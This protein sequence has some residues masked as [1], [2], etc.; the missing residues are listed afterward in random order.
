[1]SSIEK[2]DGANSPD[3][4]YQVVLSPPEFGSASNDVNLP[5]VIHAENDWTLDEIEGVSTS[6]LRIA[7]QISLA[8]LH[9]SFSLFGINMPTSVS[10][11]INVAISFIQDSWESHNA[12]V[13]V[14]VIRNQL[15]E[16][17]ASLSAANF[18]LSR[19]K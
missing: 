8:W 11:N 16:D 3:T 17:R 5:A 2:I 14:S 12:K 15:Y 13:Q 4:D 1:M 19:L 18:E 6:A 9:S 10:G 7:A